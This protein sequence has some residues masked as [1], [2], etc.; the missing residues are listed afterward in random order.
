MGEPTHLRNYAQVQL[1]HETPQIRVK[2]KQYLVNHP[3]SKTSTVHTLMNRQF[4]HNLFLAP[5]RRL[6]IEDVLNFLHKL[7]HLGSMWRAIFAARAIFFETFAKWRL[8]TGAPHANVPLLR[9]K[10]LSWAYYPLVS[11]WQDL[12]KPS[13]T[14]HGTWKA[15]WK[16]KKNHHLFHPK[17]PSWLWASKCLKISGMYI[18]KGFRFFLECFQPPS[19]TKSCEFDSCKGSKQVIP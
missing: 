15:T 12:T 14:Y 5:K 6:G 11:P 17:Q 8:S 18:F 4:P 19:T 16:L 7:I 1:D 9:N 13:E 3:S 10:A 2:I